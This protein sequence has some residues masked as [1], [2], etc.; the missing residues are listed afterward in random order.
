MVVS[1]HAIEGDQFCAVVCSNSHIFVLK[2]AENGSQSV[3][4]ASQV[5]LSDLTFPNAANNQQKLGKDNECNP[6][7]LSS[8]VSADRNLLAVATTTK[9]VLLFE[10]QSLGNAIGG[11]WE[12]TKCQTIPKTPTA[13]HFSACGDTLLV[14]TRSGS[15]LQFRVNDANFCPGGAIELLS[16]FSMLLDHCLSPGRPN[17][18]LSADRDEKVRVS[19]YPNTQIIECFCLG[20]TSFV[21]SLCCL[22]DEIAVSGGGDGI[23][24][25]WHFKMGHCLCVSPKLNN[26]PIRKL[27]PLPKKNKIFALF[28]GAS[29][30]SLFDFDPRGPSVDLLRTFVGDGQFFDFAID[31]KGRQIFAVGRKGLFRCDFGADSAESI[32]MEKADL[33]GGKWSTFSTELAN[34]TDLF[35]LEQLYKSVAFGNLE[36][37]QRKKDERKRWKRGGTE[38]AEEEEGD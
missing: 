6:S 31:E 14:G 16:H 28:D 4:L 34:S 33:E 29:E 23:L 17:F 1:I 22:N 9:H 26:S 38:L 10:L 25:V 8:D 27:F 19:R 21:N 15:L 3:E 12:E 18:L 5:D 32:A 13:I 30:I 2:F 37:Y 35:P 11:T 7:I 20:H 36:N 24:R